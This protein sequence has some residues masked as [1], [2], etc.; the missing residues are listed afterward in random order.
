ML[1]ILINK[2]CFILQLI[3]FNH[4]INGGLQLELNLQGF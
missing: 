2:F 1:L 3:H 4:C